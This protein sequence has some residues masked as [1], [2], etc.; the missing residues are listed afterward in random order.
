MKPYSTDLRERIVQAVKDDHKTAEETARQFK[1]SLATTYRF[2]QLHRDLQDLTPLKSTGRTR[3][4]QLED[5]P[6]LLEQI[7]ANNDLTL[8]EHCKLWY[9]H[10]KQTIS[11]T[12]MFESLKR[13]KISLKKSQSKP[14]NATPSIE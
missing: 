8:A 13:A 12:C 4:I 11:Q 6:R 14:K 9:K 1:I 3:L 5:E 10:T 2:L 7:N